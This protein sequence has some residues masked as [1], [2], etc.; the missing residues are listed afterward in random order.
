MYS[1]YYYNNSTTN[2]DGVT[3]SISGLTPNT[4]YNLRVWSYD[5]DSL[6]D[7]STPT[8][9]SPFNNTTGPSGTI[10]NIRNSVPT[11]LLDPDNSV[12]LPVIS[13]TGTIEVFGREVS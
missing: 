10:Q 9:W 1:D 7:S 5:V 3:L 6:V 2:G 4:P 13:T 11:E 12:V 8:Q